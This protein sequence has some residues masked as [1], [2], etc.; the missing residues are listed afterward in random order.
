MENST[1]QIQKNEE[2][3]AKVD[4]EDSNS[5]TASELNPKIKYYEPTE[6]ML[7][8]AKKVITDDSKTLSDFLY[9]KYEKDAKRNWD[10]F[11]KNNKDNFFRNRHYIER[12]FIELQAFKGKEETF[13]ICELGCGVGNTLYPL[14]EAFPNIVCYGFDFSPR[15]VKMIQE[16]E[17]SIKNPGKIIVE[18]ADLVKDPIPVSFPQPDFATLI[19]VLSA[20]SPENFKDVVKKIYDFLKPGSVLFLRDY[21]RYDMAQIKL[22]NHKKAKLKDNFY[23][24]SDGTRVY[25]LA[26]EELSALFIE[27][28]FKELENQYH[29]RLVENKKLELKMNRVWIQAK[30]IKK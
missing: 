11:Y 5:E 27:A 4:S 10:I 28:G 7:E 17:V 24:K 22:A 18:V 26:K 12:E 16:N 9:S 1:E 8:N 14:V 3:K 21:G 15:A 29:Y 19:F 6:E 13:T 20:I 30:F 2:I 25:Y 23:V